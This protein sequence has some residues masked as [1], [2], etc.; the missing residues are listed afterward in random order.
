MTKKEEQCCG[1]CSNFLYEDLLGNG[2]C[3]V[4]Q[5]ESYCADGTVCESFTTEPRPTCVQCKHWNMAFDHSC[6]MRIAKHNDFSDQPADQTACE[7]FEPEEI[8]K[9]E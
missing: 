1:S 2:I 8:T 9:G 5:K 7:D 6:A 3:A 4:T